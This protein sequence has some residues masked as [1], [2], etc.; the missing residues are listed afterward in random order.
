MKR[1]L[2]LFAESTNI[3]NINLPGPAKP[4]PNALVRSRFYGVPHENMAFVDRPDIAERIFKSLSNTSS[5]GCR[6]V[7]LRGRGGTGKTQM[8]LRYYYANRHA[9]KY[10]FWMVMDTKSSAIS[11]YRDLAIN[12]GLDDKTAM[13]GSEKKVVEW[14]RSWLQGRTGWILLLDNADDVMSSEVFQHLPRFGGDIII[15]TRDF[16]PPTKAEV[17]P[18]DKMTKEEALS[19]LLGPSP[20]DGGVQHAQEIVV[21]LDYLPLAINLAHAYI[22]NMGISLKEYLE[23]FKDR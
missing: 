19:L 16:I 22:S 7:V 10:A 6:I 15:T 18:I 12:L 14:V 20:I 3:T 1:N 8:M 21:E 2:L 4:D 13:D 11:S 17:I 23:Q 9:Y 5:H